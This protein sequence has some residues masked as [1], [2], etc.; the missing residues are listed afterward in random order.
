MGLGIGENFL[1]SDAQ[2]L[3]QVTNRMLYLDE[4]DVVEITRVSRVRIDAADV[5]A[6][7]DGERV[8]PLPV[9]V[10][11]VPGALRVFA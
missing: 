6:Y 10:E 3:I 7:A 11:V 4:D 9:T 8:G 2:A 1:G 5:I